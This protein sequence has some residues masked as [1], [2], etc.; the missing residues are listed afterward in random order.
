MKRSRLNPIS[1][2]RRAKQAA[3]RDERYVDAMGV[4]FADYTTCL[5]P[6]VSNWPEGPARVEVDCEKAQA[7]FHEDFAGKPCWWC[8]EH[9]KMELHHLGGGSLGR[10]HE[11][12]L[13]CWT[14]SACHREHVGKEDLGRWLYLKWREDRA[15]TFWFLLAIRLR[16]YLPELI[17]DQ[18]HERDRG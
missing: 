2:K 13:F 3:V 8:G 16:R 15:N 6:P 9:G 4:A 14:C 1:A 5:V 12:I 18:P 17:T 10:S 11:R 7:K